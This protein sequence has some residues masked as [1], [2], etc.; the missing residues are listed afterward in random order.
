MNYERLSGRASSASW[1]RARS[2]PRLCVKGVDGRRPLPEVFGHRGRF[3][4]PGNVDRVRRRNFRPMLIDKAID[5]VIRVRQRH[6]ITWT[7]RMSTL[8]RWHD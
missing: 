6:V 3:S 7:Q 5:D 4:L 1:L 8:N 2:Q